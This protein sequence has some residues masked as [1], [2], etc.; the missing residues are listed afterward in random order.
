[1]TILGWS[2]CLWILYSLQACLEWT[3]TNER[4]KL[5]RERKGK[6]KV[7]DILVVVLFLLFSPVLVELVDLHSSIS[8]LKQV[9]CL[10]ATTENG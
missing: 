9:K 7:G 4:E 2:S 3:Q 5:G 1:M 6:K 8:L 10:H